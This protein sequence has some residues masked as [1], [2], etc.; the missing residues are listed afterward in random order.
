MHIVTMF[1]IADKQFPIPITCRDVYKLMCLR[2]AHHFCSFSYGIIFDFEVRTKR[3]KCCT[4]SIFFPIYHSLNH[5]IRHYSVR[6]FL[7]HSVDW[8]TLSAF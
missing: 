4:T 8:G 7:N 5:F 1:P 6:E 2:A 3:E